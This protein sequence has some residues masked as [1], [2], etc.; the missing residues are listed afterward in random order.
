MQVKLLL[1]WQFISNFQPPTDGMFIKALWQFSDIFSLESVM[2]FEAEILPQQ[3]WIPPKVPAISTI[4][5][6]YFAAIWR[7]PKMGVPQK[8]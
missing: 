7:F 4:I 1:S 3:N 8:P 6:L 5:Q 2:F